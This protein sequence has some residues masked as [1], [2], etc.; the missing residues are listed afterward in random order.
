MQ[1]RAAIL[2]H[3]GASAPFAASRPLTTETVTL[4]APGPGEVLG[5][6]AAAG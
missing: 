5:R 3:K 4:D 6:I 1:T 2:R